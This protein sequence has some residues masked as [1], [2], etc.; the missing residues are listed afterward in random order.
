ML[1]LRRPTAIIEEDLG[2]A[3]ARVNRRK[4]HCWKF[5]TD[6]V[7][8]QIPGEQKRKTGCLSTCPMATELHLHGHTVLKG[9]CF[10]HK[11]MIPEIRSRFS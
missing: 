10:P 4:I 1:P 11:Y 3:S 8:P 2:V 5:K 6:L 7:C 9:T